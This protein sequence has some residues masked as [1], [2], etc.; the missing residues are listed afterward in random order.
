MYDLVINRKLYFTI[1]I[2]SNASEN[3]V[4]SLPDTEQSSLAASHDVQSKE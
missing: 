1:Y 4:V 3:A 2:L